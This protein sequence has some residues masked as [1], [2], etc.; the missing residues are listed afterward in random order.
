M[1]PLEASVGTSRKEARPRDGLPP[2]LAMMR[3]LLPYLYPENFGATFLILG[4][5]KGN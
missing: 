4:G 3:I 1:A 5:E 2:F